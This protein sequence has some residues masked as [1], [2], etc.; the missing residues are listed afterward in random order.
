MPITES[1]AAG[2]IG[3]EIGRLERLVK[4]IKAPQLRR[5]SLDDGTIPVTDAAQRR[6]FMIGKLAD[7]TFGIRWNRTLIAA[8]PRPSAAASIRQRGSLPA[9]GAN[10]EIEWNGMT[11]AD[12]GE[13]SGPAIPHD[14]AGV[15]LCHVLQG[16]T[17]LITFRPGV[18]PGQT[19]RFMTANI[20]STWHTHGY[21][22]R[23][24]NQ[25]GL[26]SQLSPVLT[27]NDFL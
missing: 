25:A 6:V 18:N 4:A 20:A 26:R 23:L 24:V 14:I 3:H 2:E 11:L 17:S 19:H 22:F 13:P 5:M 16:V 27:G 9:G 21:A 1:D 7:G 10:V 8:P 15:E 12:E